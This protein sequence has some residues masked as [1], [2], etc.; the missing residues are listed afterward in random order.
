MAYGYNLN[1]YYQQNPIVAPI[2]TVQQNSGIIWV[3]GENAAKAY[4]VSAGQS[5]ILMDTEDNVMYIKSTDQSGMPLQLRAFEYKERI[6]N[7]SK[8]SKT[9]EYISRDEFDQFR[10]EIKN[11][12]KRAKSRV[13]ESKKEIRNA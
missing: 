1:P 3:Q 9:N 11:E 7:G 8:A 13:D 12:L 6:A 2:N 4:P 10:E 5:V